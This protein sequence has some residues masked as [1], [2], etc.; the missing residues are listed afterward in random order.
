[1]FR[2]SDAILLMP[3]TVFVPPLIAHHQSHRPDPVPSA[4]I[5]LA[6]GF[7]WPIGR[8][9]A[10]GY[11]DAQPFGVNTHLGEDWNANTGAN[12]DLG[13]PVYAIGHG[14]V[15]FAGYVRGGWGNIVR[16]VHTYEEDGT[17]RQIESFYAH[18]DEIAV[19]EGQ[20]LRRGALVGTIGDADGRYYA[21]LH[22]ELRDEVGLPHGPG[23]AEDT[24]G[25][26]SPS[27]FI[28]AHRRLKGPAQR[29]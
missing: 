13:D 28:A 2:V 6:D 25:W 20:V 12:T 11:Y 24:R 9:D 5:P 19:E 17:T 16:V 22:L 10:R 7:D 18:L 4:E 21:H 8:P 3:F 29:P 15:S 26:L 14:V 1:M 23:Y 27:A